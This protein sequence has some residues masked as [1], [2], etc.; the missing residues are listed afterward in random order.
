MNCFI[1]MFNILTEL[2]VA[3]TTVYLINK[4]DKTLVP[5]GDRKSQ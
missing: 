5:E 4:T 3:K 2:L 1:K